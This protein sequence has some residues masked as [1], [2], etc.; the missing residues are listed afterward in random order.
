MHLPQQ[1][2]DE[3]PG[4]CILQV[5]A[6]LALPVRMFLAGAGHVHR[7]QHADEV[8]GLQHD[9]RG[10]AAREEYVD[11]ERERLGI[12]AR[13]SFASSRPEPGRLERREQRVPVAAFQSTFESGWTLLDLNTLGEYHQAWVVTMF[14]A[15]GRYAAGIAAAQPV[16]SC[17][18]LFAP[19]P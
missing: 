16:P 18:Q 6:H 11:R 7:V 19:A 14:K 5:D 15:E 13:R 1:L 2:V 4:E 17:Q 12:R 8:L 9:Q 10:R 3:P